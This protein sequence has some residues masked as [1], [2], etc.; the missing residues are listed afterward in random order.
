MT[1]SATGKALNRKQ[2]RA[3]NRSN[4]LRKEFQP[5]IVEPLASGQAVSLKTRT[6]YCVT[7]F[8]SNNPEVKAKEVVSVSVK[9]PDHLAV[10]ANRA[11]KVGR[12]SI[13]LGLLPTVAGTVKVCLTEKQDSPA[14]SFKRALAVADSSKEVASAFYVD[15]F[16]DVSLGDL[17]KDLSI[18]LYSEAALAANSIRIRMEVE[19]V[20]PKFITRFSPFA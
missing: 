2:R 16:K 13:L 1:T 8:V 19:H 6:G 15:G 3:L 10:E 5:V 20:M 12:I 18:Y 17:E 4:R 9:L 11:L 7:Q 14:E